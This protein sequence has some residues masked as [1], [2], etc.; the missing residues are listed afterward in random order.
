MIDWSPTSPDAGIYHPKFGNFGLR[1]E[2]VG[3]ISYPPYPTAGK[4]RDGLSPSPRKSQ[5][6]FSANSAAS[7][8]KE[9]KKSVILIPTVM[10]QTIVNS[11]VRRYANGAWSEEARGAPAE[12]PVTLTVNGE[13][14][15]EFM[16]TPEYLEALAVGFLF[17][18]GLVDRA[19]DVAQVH[20]CAAGDNV[21]V[22]TARP[23]EKPARW[24]RTSGCTGGLTAA[25]D[26]PHAVELPPPPRGMPVRF[27]DIS[28]P[29]KQISALVKTLLETQELHR[30]SGGVHASALSDGE[31]LLLSCE[32]VGRHN[33][34]D[35]LS[36]RVLLE[37]V[38]AP[39]RMV[40][41]TGRV[42]SEM[43]QKSARM[44]T[45]AVVS[46]TSPT[47][48]AVQMA[49]AWGITLIGYARQ[50]RFSVYT[51]S[52]RIIEAH[53]KGQDE[54]RPKYRQKATAKGKRKSR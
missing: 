5:L 51:H 27:D 53:I 4:L 36:G 32:D 35:K 40:L 25:G 14:W 16:C 3:R 39:R 21:D 13:P 37:N 38:T 34:L 15:L 29:P 48:I 7:A 54:S 2:H 23:V 18:E 44:G 1:R 46:C 26:E 31:K 17:N 22:W 41:T 47:L 20:V 24:R 10:S 33:T 42:S 28:F 11:N 49:E 8:V 6:V 12:T 9:N 30:Q 19:A 45:A 52:R 43:L 50:E